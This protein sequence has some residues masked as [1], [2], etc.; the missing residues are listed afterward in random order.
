MLLLPAPPRIVGRGV[1][2]GTPVVRGK[3]DR[4]ILLDAQFFDRIQYLADLMVH[5]LDERN[6][7]RPFLTQLGLAL[8]DLLQPILGGLDGEVRGVVSQVEK[9]GLLFVRRLFL[10]IIDRPLA[11]DLGGMPLGLDDLLVLSIRFTP[12][13]KW[14]E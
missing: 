4:G 14:V 8:L 3:G 12:P 5:V 9:E 13:R 6:V 7:G 2:D 1:R 11:E 10:D